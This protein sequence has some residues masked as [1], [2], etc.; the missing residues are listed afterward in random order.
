MTDAFILHHYDRSPYA[1]KVRLMFGVTNSEWQ[2]LL[3]PPWPP[4]PNVDPLAGGYR[5]I[6]VAQCGADIFCDSAVIAEEVALFK[7]EVDA[8]QSRLTQIKQ[9]YPGM[10]EVLP[11][12]VDPF[13]GEFQKA[14]RKFKQSRRGRPSW[15][16][17]AGVDAPLGQGVDAPALPDAT[18]VIGPEDLIDIAFEMR[19]MEKAA[20][21]AGD[22]PELSSEEVARQAH[23]RAAIK[24]SILLQERALTATER[25]AVYDV[26]QKAGKLG[27]A[28]AEKQMMEYEVSFGKMEALPEVSEL[29]MSQMSSSWGGSEVTGTTGTTVD[30]RGSIT[31]TI[32]GEAVTA[33]DT[34]SGTVS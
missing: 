3:S 22:M 28:L 23:E 8:M 20:K 9:Q 14:W 25:R 31:D 21:A 26:Q 29:T 12:D 32:L 34:A 6:P 13:M 2:S 7:S 17:E 11:A 15:S 30:L 27:R 16:E 4:R 18:G 10:T 19:K 1:E 5:R 33:L 24:K